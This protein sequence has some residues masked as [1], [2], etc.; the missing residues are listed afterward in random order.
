MAGIVGVGKVFRK[1]ENT[2]GAFVNQLN[3]QASPAWLTVLDDVEQERP[4][5]QFTGVGVIAAIVHLDLNALLTERAAVV[6]GEGNLKLLRVGV[7]GHEIGAVGS[8]HEVAQRGLWV[9]DMSNHADLGVHITHDGGDGVSDDE[10]SS[11][12]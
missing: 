3:G 1:G 11:V 8:D 2:C 10:R 5:G 7:P 6:V 4:V 9:G 12:R